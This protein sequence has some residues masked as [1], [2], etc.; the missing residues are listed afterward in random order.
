MYVYMYVY[1]Y[2]FVRV[3]MRIYVYIC[4]CIYICRYIYVQVFGFQEFVFGFGIGVQSFGVFFLGY[5]FFLVLF[6]DYLYVQQLE[7]IG[8]V[9]ILEMDIQEFLVNIVRLVCFSFRYRV[10]LIMFIVC[11]VIKVF[12]QVQGDMRQFEGQRVQFGFQSRLVSLGLIR[13]FFVQGF[14][15]QFVGFLRLGYFY[16]ILWFQNF[17][18]SQSRS[19][20]WEQFWM[21]EC[22]GNCGGNR[23]GGYGAFRSYVRGFVKVQILCG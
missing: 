8:G 23:Y 6:Q 15:V 19:V 13:R 21:Y 1:I 4:I 7:Q 12:C 14:L 2:V 9:L 18:L 22:L 11:E 5:C 3:Y 17:F 10:S 20:G 16:K